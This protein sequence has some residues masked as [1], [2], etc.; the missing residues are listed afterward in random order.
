MTMRRAG[1]GLAL[2]LWASLAAAAGPPALP[3]GA[4]RAYG[5]LAAR[6]SAADARDVVAR[7]DGTWRLAG[8]PAY[9]AALDFIRERLTAAGFSASAAAAATI[10]VEA[11]PA[12]SPGWDYRVGTVAFAVYQRA[13]V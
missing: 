3:P 7:M 5:V 4:E 10:A 8:N 1:A 12:A 13:V 6:V 2:V 9:D 11:F